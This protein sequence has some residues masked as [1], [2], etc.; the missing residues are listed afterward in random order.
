ME[1]WL[2]NFLSEKLLMTRHSGKRGTDCEIGKNSNAKHS[3]DY[4]DRAEGR[5]NKRQWA[6]PE[7]CRFQA[8]ARA[9]REK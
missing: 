9:I 7:H 4:S 6:Y 1:S 5:G 3:P 8:P 2:L